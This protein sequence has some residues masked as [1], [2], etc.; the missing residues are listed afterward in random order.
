MLTWVLAHVEALKPAGTCEQCLFVISTWFYFPARLLFKDEVL[1][2][3]V[4]VAVEEFQPMEDARVLSVL[5]SASQ[6]LVCM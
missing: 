3:S 4:E 6:A 1:K 2:S 5:V